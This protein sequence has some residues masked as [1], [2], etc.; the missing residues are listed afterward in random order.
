MHLID[1]NSANTEIVVPTLT[2]M[3][4]SQ[5]VGVAGACQFQVSKAA[6]A[7]IERAC[8]HVMGSYISTQK[9]LRTN[10]ELFNDDHYPLS[11]NWTRML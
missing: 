3:R 5:P 7:R 8:A 11:E 4:V 10:M 2:A 1:T 9:C 6:A